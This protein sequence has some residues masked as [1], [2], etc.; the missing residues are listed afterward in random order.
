MSLTNDIYDFI[1]S[2]TRQYGS[3]PILPVG[4]LSPKADSHENTPN[5][6]HTY[7][8]VTPIS[9]SLQVATTVEKRVSEPN[10]YL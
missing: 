8:E 7:L 9:D 2:Y 5:I 6:L 3:K 1:Q 10:E 4:S